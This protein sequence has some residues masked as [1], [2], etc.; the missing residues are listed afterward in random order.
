VFAILLLKVFAAFCAAE[1]TDEKKPPCWLEPG[2][3]EFS[4]VGVRGAEVM[5][6]SLLGPR[7]PEFVLTRRCDIIFPEGD[8]TTFTFT[9]AVGSD[10]PRSRVE[11]NWGIPESVGVGG[12]LTIGG[13]ILSLAGG[14]CGREFVSIRCG[15]FVGFG[16]SGRFMTTGGSGG[17]GGA[18]S[19]P[20]K[21]EPILDTTLPRLP[22]LPPFLSFCTPV[23]RPP[24][25][26]AF[27]S[28]LVLGPRLGLNASRNRPIGEGDLFIDPPIS[29]CKPP[30]LTS[31]KDCVAAS[32]LD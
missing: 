15:I 2:L 4:G 27:R 22:S 10:V 12:V 11:G 17:M 7:V 30:I 1:K 8:V 14:V 29:G 26:P 28:G 25:L 23:S 19:L 21:M 16:G 20:G 5:F 13:A 24:V 31:G 6:E 3:V 32:V 18:V 9:E